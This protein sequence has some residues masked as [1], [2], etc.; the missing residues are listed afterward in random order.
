MA[1]CDE[2]QL[3]LPPRPA[4]ALGDVIGDGPRGG[5]RAPTE[6]ANC[7]TR[8][9]ISRP[10]D[11]DERL[12]VSCPVAGPLLVPLL[13]SVFGWWDGESI[14]WRDDD[15]NDSDSDSDGEEGVS[16]HRLSASH[17]SK[18][19]QRVVL[20]RRYSDKIRLLMRLL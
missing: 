15:D 18:D 11:D 17:G 7:A 2:L 20:Q 3:L 6:E 1:T 14:C 4:E 19:A 13:P 8:P 12:T 9:V 5:R 10:L 16:N